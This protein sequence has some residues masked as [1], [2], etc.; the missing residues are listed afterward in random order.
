[1]KTK[2]IDFDIDLAKKIQAGE[3]QGRIVTRDGQPARIICWDKECCGSDNQPI[4]ALLRYVPNSDG[5]FCR[6]YTVKGKAKGENLS[7]LF[8]EVP[9]DTPQFQPYDKVLA[10]RIK[11]DKWS[12]T[13]YSHFE[14]EHHNCMGILFKHCIPYEGNEHLVGTTDEPKE[15][16]AE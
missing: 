16:G 6:L 12:C 13:F 15:G 9:D 3:A 14:G 7:D 10:R 1:M 8:L 2:R 4:V 5:E 11:S